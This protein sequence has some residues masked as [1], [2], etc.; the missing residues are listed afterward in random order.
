MKDWD[1][2][3]WE[4]AAAAIQA[5][6]MP[7]VR[8]ILEISSRNE[9][10]PAMSN[11]AAARLLDIAMLCGN[12]EAATNLAKSCQARP[13]RRW[14]GDELW[15]GLN[16]YL[17]SATLSTISAAL[18][19]GADFHQ[20]HTSLYLRRLGHCVPVLKVVSLRY[21]PEEWQKVKQIFPADK[22]RWPT[23]YLELG[24][25]FLSLERYDGPERSLLPHDT[26]QANVSLCM[27]QN[28]LSRGWNLAFVEVGLEECFNYKAFS[29]G[30]TLLDL[31]I[32]CGQPECADV[33]ASAGVELDAKP[34]L[35]RRLEMHK[36]LFLGEDLEVGLR[37]DDKIY[38]KRGSA[39]QCK[40]AASAAARASL[41]R[42][43][44]REGTEKGIAMYQ[45]LVKEFYPRGVPIVLVHH[46]LSLSM[47]VPGIMDQLD[48]WDEVSGWT[49][50]W[51]DSE[52]VGRHSAETAQE[53][54]A[55][56]I[57]L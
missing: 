40:A 24:R 26:M 13:L 57:R 53:P 18:S 27:I 47:E 16:S 12:V 10:L 55:L 36:Q 54:S 37:L 41:T 45:I 30:G 7:L 21:E 23:E 31:A 52:A 3:L 9:P 4:A 51:E 38:V 46:I 6:K 44:Q 33:L 11:K 28:A 20:L 15:M 50:S 2:N 8:G 48:L 39:I 56:G 19:A 35:E 29:R 5:A 43:F 1:A 25:V 42:S 17:A 14:K 49:P 22:G 32:L 34:H